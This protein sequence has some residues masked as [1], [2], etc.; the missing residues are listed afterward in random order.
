MGTRSRAT[1]GPDWTVGDVRTTARE[2]ARL[3]VAWRTD[4]APQG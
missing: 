3:A 2:N 1:Y 4:P